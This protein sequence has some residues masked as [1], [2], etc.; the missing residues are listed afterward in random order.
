MKKAKLSFTKVYLIYLSVLVVAMIAAIAYV[1]VL[2]HQYEDS[3]PERCVE[4]AMEMLAEDAANGELFT[5][6]ELPEIQ[7]GKFEEKIDVKKAYQARFVPE[8]MSFSVK[9]G[10]HEED[11]LFYV[12]ENAGTVLAEVKLKATGPAVTKLAVL[13]VRE[14][15]IE[16]IKPVLEQVDYTLS[17]PLDFVVCVND[18]MLTSGDGDVSDEK[19]IT[20]TIPGVYLAPDLDIRDR[21][22]NEVSYTVDKDKILAEFCDYALTLPETLTVHVNGSLFVGEAQGNNR[23]FYNIRMLEKPEVVISDYYGNSIRYEGEKE[24]PL[25]YMTI[26]AD[27]RYSVT[28]EGENLAKEAVTVS[29]NKEYAQLADYVEN[30]PRIS[31]INIAVLKKDAE[32]LIAD[33]AGNPV[34]FQPGEAFYDFTDNKSVLQDVP[35]EVRAEVDIIGI[36]QAWSLFMSNDKRFAELEP[37]LIADSYQ[38]NVAKQYATGVDITFTSE[39]TL[40]NPAFTDASVSDF[41]WIADNC[42]SVDVSFVKHMILRT[43]KRVDDPMNDRFYFVK[44]DDTEDGIHNPTW[45]IASMKEIVSNGK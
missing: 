8:D 1:N 39:H 38:Y 10:S 6:Y 5:K 25:T 22:G 12:V 18:V 34:S 19:K 35:D 4:Q 24:I 13:S 44:Y 40:A 14:W 31:E 45:K 11:E 42:F 41:V 32:I 15:Q 3:R 17:V 23:V 36:A 2:L 20:Y 43:G 28:V 9:N 26:L 16:E 7:K 37:Y 29:E 27:G 21:D 33:E 30:L